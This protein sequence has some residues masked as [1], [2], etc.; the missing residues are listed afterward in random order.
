MA[1]AWEAV[2]MEVAAIAMAEEVSYPLSY[3]KKT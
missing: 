1:A 3:L 2:P